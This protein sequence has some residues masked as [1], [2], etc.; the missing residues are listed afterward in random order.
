MDLLLYANLVLNS[1]EGERVQ[2]PL[3]FKNLVK[4]AVFQHFL[5]HR[6]CILIKVKHGTEKHLTGVR[7]C[8]KF[9]CYL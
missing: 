8:T 1:E 7:Q 3:I 9:H 4:I 2:E 5:H 6:V